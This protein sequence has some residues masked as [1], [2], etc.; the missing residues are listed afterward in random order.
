MMIGLATLSAGPSPDIPIPPVPPT[1]PPT[2]ESAPTPNDGVRPPV[3]VANGDPQFQLRLFRSRQY[4]WSQGFLP[5]SRY[6]STEDRKAIQTPGLS[7]TV[8]LQ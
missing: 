2:G 8:P 7:I 1:R 5:G 6:E 4:D 3:V